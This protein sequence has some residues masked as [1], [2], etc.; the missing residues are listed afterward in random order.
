MLAGTAPP[1]AA[2]MFQDPAL[3]TLY[4][5]ERYGDLGRAGQQRL[6]A[7][8]DDL[9]ALLAAGIGALQQGDAARREAVIAQAEACLQRQPQAAVCHYTLGVVLGV[10]AANAGMFKLA[11]SIGRVKGALQQALA[12]APQWHAARGAVV[13]FYLLAPAMLGGGVD[14][15]RATAQAAPRP[16]QQRALQA[17]VAL[18]DRQYEA[19][20]AQLQAIHPG[21]DSAL[22]ADI[23]AWTRGAAFGLVNERQPEKARPTFERLRR[24][25]PAL[26]VGHYGLGRVLSDTGAPEQALALY[27]QAAA[28]QGADTLPLDHRIGIALQQLGRTDAARAALQRFVAAGKG[29]KANL[30]DAKQRLAQLGT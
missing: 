9:Q 5:A 10:H 11:S 12:L 22:A 3:D 1:A 15:A 27:A 25:R 6:A 30:D 21:A 28:L 7:N 20:L 4:A 2:Q 17:R 8:A 29:P 13:E 18:Q 24:E 14:Q 26:A 16:E 23:D 19:A